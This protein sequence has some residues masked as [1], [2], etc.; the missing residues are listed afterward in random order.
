MYEVS[1]EGKGAQEA[2]VPHQGD[3]I[4]YKERSIE[5]PEMSNRE[6]R[7]DLIIIGRVVTTQASLNMMPRVVESIIVMIRI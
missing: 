6:I 2:Q 4:P 3:H 7:E 5:V 1:Q